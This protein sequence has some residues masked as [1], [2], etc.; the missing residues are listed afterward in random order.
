MT[1]SLFN[2]PVVWLV[3]A[4][5]VLIVLAVTAGYYLW[6]VRK[7]QQ[8]QQQQREALQEEGAKQ[9][10]RIN[11]SIQILAQG[12]LDDQLTL[13]EASIRIRVLLDSLSVTDDV[14]DN[15][16][17][18]YLLADATDHIPILDQWKALSTKKKLQLTK[19]REKLETDHREFVEDAARR[20]R[21][22]RF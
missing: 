8:R 17:A 1:E 13:T 19:E 14:R 9:R 22:Q 4:T 12:I 18:F 20:I 6:Q 2:N 10:Q 15:Y 3:L 11:N 5:L 16:K 7:L 21:G